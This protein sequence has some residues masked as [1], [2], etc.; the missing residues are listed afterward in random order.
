MVS[1][2]RWE[3][4]GVSSSER[5]SGGVGRTKRTEILGDSEKSLLTRVFGLE[6]V[7]VKIPGTKF[8]LDPVQAAF[9]IGTQV[10]RPRRARLT[11]SFLDEAEMFFAR[12][13]NS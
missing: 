13:L 5:E 12:L 1:S 10:S 9:N 8:E 4:G 2:E 7:G 3:G 11:C 6:R